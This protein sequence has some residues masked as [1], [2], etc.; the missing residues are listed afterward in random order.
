MVFAYKSFV[1]LDIAEAIKVEV[2]FRNP[3]QIPISISN[4]T[5]IC[6]HSSECN[7]SESGTFL[8]MIYVHYLLECA[9]LLTSSN[10]LVE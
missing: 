7:E 2:S 1:L 10:V 8:H 6:K 3:L 4:V 9:S 5:L